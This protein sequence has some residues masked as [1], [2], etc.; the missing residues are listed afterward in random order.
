M[1][2]YPAASTG[3]VSALAAATGLSE[4][5]SVAVDENGNIYAANACNG[6]V[7]IYAKGSNGN[8][9]PIATIGGSNTGLELPW[10][11]ALDSKGNI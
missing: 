11:I 10:G 9:A 3:D 8:A 2:A 4:P 1:T 6:T 7:T 5:E